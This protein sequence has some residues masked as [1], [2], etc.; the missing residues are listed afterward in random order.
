MDSSPSL[1]LLVPLPRPQRGGSTRVQ[2]GNSEAILESTRGGHSFL[3][4]NGRTARRFVLGLPAHGQLNVTLRAPRFALRVVPRELL[5]LVPGGRVAG[6][7][8]VA[9]VPTLSW[10][11]SAARAHTLL[12]L[13]PEEQAAEWDQDSGHVLHAESPW[14]VR[15]PLRNG[16]ARAI[17][18]VRVRHRGGDAAQVPH[19]ELSLRDAELRSMR[20]S[21]VAA[22]RRFDANGRELEHTRCGSLRT[23]ASA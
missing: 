12:E 15:F 16:E 7:V 6:Y 3:W 5:T 21:I 1:P 22:P 10:H 19:F 13:P 11:D 20:G 2:V 9:L 8:H 17:V 4:T 18:P 14:F 23:G